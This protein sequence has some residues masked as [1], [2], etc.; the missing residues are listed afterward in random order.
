MPRNRKPATLDEAERARDRRER[1]ARERRIKKILAEV[2]KLPI[3]D[4]RPADEML[5][6][7]DGLPK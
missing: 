7:E 1:A 4:P 5:Y 3:L 2:R 6:D